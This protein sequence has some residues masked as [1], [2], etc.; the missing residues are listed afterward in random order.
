MSATRPDRRITRAEGAT[1][2]ALH[3]N[4]HAI[5]A[6]VRQYRDGERRSSGRQDS[7]DSILALAVALTRAAHDLVVGAR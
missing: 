1:L 2:R 4:S 5:L 3:A 6:H 7:A